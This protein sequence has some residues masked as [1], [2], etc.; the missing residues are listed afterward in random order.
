MGYR[1]HGTATEV[2]ALQLVKVSASMQGIKI[3]MRIVEAIDP[4][5]GDNAGVGVA[6]ENLSQHLDAVICRSSI[7]TLFA[8]E[9]VHMM[10]TYLCEY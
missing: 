8:C 9:R 2:P 3:G 5:V 7:S 4:F 1:Y 10:K 6:H